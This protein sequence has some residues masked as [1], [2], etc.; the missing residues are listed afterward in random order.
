VT[1]VVL[2]SATGAPGT[3]TTTL[4]MAL[5]WPRPCLVVEAD[6]SGG[7]SIL[8]GYHRGTVPHDRGLVDLAMAHRRGLLA[9]GLHRVSIPLG[10]STTARLIPGLTGPEQVPT[11]QALWEPLTIALRGLEQVGVD[12]LVDAGRLGTVGGPSPLV[13]EAGV[14]LSSIG[15]VVAGDGGPKFIDAQGKEIALERLSYSHF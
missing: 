9:E 3:T 12:V 5:Q 4:A 13:R 11:A 8:A 7:S 15:T 10:D 14:A 2:T 1:L 6:M